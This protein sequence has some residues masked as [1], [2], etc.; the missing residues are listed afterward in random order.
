MN[1]FNALTSVVPTPMSTRLRPKL[2]SA[3]QLLCNVFSA[4]LGQL[5]LACE[6]ASCIVTIGSRPH[7]QVLLG[8]LVLFRG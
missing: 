3:P 1:S 8:D 2:R 4:N 5:P 7:R 6:A